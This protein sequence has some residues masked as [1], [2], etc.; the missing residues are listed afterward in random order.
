MVSD[1]QAQPVQPDNLNATEQ[2][3]VATLKE[4]E[5]LSGSERTNCGEAAKKKF[6]QM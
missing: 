2:K 3:Y 1:T 4:C 6:R 5:T